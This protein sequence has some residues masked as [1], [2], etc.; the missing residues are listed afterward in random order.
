MILLIKGRVLGF[1]GLT[2]LAYLPMCLVN[3]VNPFESH[4]AL[5]CT[6]LYYFTLWV[7]HFATTL[8]HAIISTWINMEMAKMSSKI[9]DYWYI[10]ILLIIS[11]RHNC[12][13]HKG[14]GGGQLPPSPKNSWK[15]FNSDWIAVCMYV[16]QRAGQTNS[17]DRSLEYCSHDTHQLPHSLLHF[18]GRILQQ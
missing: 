12:G 18:I 2:V 9:T 7:K 11:G 14:G 15:P 17:N 16:Y 8:L 4:C 1:N 13:G 5:I 10:N 6:L 3:L